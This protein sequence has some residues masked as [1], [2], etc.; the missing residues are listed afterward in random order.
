MWEA[1]S[2]RSMAESVYSGLLK[3]D[4]GLCLGGASVVF[5]LT[6]LPSSSTQ[7]VL[8]FSFVWQLLVPCTLQLFS[9]GAYS[10]DSPLLLLMLPSSFSL[11]VSPGTRDS[12]S[13]SCM[14][15]Q[16]HSLQYLWYTSSHT[17]VCFAGTGFR[18][19]PCGRSSHCLENSPWG[20]F[21]TGNSSSV[22]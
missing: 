10:F 12:E 6:T 2:S 15:I 18:R 14:E 13:H 11:D 22:F 16:G 5:A 20:L 4:A 1:Q 19:D 21:T 7:S 3:R 17:I 8:L 9:Y